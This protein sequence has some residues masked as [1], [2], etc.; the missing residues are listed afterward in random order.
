M[1]SIR[2]VEVIRAVMVARSISGAAQL[3]NVSPAAVSRMLRHTESQIGFALFSRTPNGFVPMPEAHALLDDLEQVHS[4]LMRIEARL[5]GS[6]HTETA[7]RIGS[8][9]GLGLSVVPRSLSALQSRQPE[10]RIELGGLHVN[11]VLPLLEFRRYDFALT[12][13]EID[14]PRLETRQIADAPLVCLMPQDHPLAGSVQVTLEDI[15]AYPMIGYDTQAFQQ[16]LIDEMF[17]RRGLT[18]DYRVRCRLMNTA[19]VLVQ[20]KLGITLLDRF[21]VHGRIPEGTCV[22]A[23]DIDY[24]FPLN[25]I[26][27]R[28]APLSREAEGF[29]DEV[30][31]I[32]SG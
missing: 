22:A 19:C 3:L 13:Y 8:S 23:I 31:R 28:D 30:K 7:L 25:V 18:P 4:S 16:R 20:E 21:T 29:L 2:Q 32:V 24:R 26:C 6:A 5:I 11:E 14:D 10:L 9:P 27:M 1:I 15:A 12:I 17:R